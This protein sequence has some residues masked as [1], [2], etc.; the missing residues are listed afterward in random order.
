MKVRQLFHL[1]TAFLGNSLSD[2]LTKEHDSF[3]KL[4][5]LSVSLGEIDALTESRS[6]VS[7]QVTQLVDVASSDPLRLVVTLV[8]GKP[9]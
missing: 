5:L 8:L 1:K 6:H 9:K 2:S 3:S 4:E 7:R